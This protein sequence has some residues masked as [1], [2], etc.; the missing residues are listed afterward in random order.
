[1]HGILQKRGISKFG[2]RV[3]LY[4]KKENTMDPMVKILW[5]KILRAES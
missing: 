1:M 5:T 3:L 2:K 4:T